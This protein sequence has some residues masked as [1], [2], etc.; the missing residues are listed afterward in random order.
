[1]N[2]NNL[3][4]LRNPSISVDSCND[5]LSQRTM[6]PAPNANNMPNLAMTFM[7]KQK[8]KPGIATA[9]NTARKK[10]PKI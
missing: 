2:F 3:S 9:R 7:S 8:S 10:E 5:N 6:K 4:P 1:M